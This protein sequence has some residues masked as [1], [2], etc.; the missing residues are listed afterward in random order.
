MARKKMKW[1]RGKALETVI[2]FR[3]IRPGD[4]LKLRLHPAG[5]WND[6][7]VASWVKRR[8][9]LIVLAIT[10]DSDCPISVKD[11]DAKVYRDDIICYEHIRAWSPDGKQH[12]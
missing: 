11:D 5:V 4:K 2:A 9:T 6:H 3:G 10:D 8:S 12:S 7:V 1:I